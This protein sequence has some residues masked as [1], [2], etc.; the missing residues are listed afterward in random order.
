MYWLAQPREECSDPRQHCRIPEY[1]ELSEQYSV[2]QGGE[3]LAAPTPPPLAGRCEPTR[4]G[5]TPGN[6]R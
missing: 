5:E 4:G 2:R 6:I 1:F 3:Q